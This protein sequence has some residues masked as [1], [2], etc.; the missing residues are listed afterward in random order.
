MLNSLE[1]RRELL[2]LIWGLYWKHVSR[3]NPLAEAHRGFY[4]KCS[5]QP[6]GEQAPRHRS[7]LRGW[8]SGRSCRVVSVTLVCVSEQGPPVVSH[9]RPQEKQVP[10]LRAFSSLSP[11]QHQ[12]SGWQEQIAREKESTALTNPL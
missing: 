2:L 9:L 7:A 5:Q 12:Q 8:W 10:N 6:E 3:W 1:E 11:G 4:N